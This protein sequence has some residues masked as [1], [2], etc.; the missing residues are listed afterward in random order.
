MFFHSNYLHWIYNM[1]TLFLI[2][3]ALEYS[4]LPNIGLM[5][6]GGFITNCYV[7]LMMEGIFLGFSGAIS[8]ALGL[9]VGYLIVN[10]GYLR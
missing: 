4:W 9:Y 5:I 10:W 8:A 3:P 6:L 1:I 2:V 7:I